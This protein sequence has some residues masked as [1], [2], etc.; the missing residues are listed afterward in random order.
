MIQIPVKAFSFENSKVLS[1]AYCDSSK[2]GRSTA[3]YVA[4][5]L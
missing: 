5:V 2:P 3:R 1:R 4:F